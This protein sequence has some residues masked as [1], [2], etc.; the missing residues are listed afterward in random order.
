MDLVGGVP[1]FVW[2]SRWCLGAVLG[3]DRALGCLGLVACLRNE[4]A[5]MIYVRE[6]I[7]IT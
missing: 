3:Y 5:M 2:V 6:Q 1:V 7:R 4:I